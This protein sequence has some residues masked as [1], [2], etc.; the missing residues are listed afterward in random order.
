ATAWVPPLAGRARR[1]LRKAREAE[2]QVL[3][4]H[5][6]ET[7]LGLQ[8]RRVDALFA[9]PAPKDVAAAEVE[10]RQALAAWVELADDVEPPAE[11]AVSYPSFRDV[12]LCPE[13]TRPAVA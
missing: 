3:A 5:G 4:A 7:W 9:Q 6:Y 12:L 13:A 8:L 2:A 11:A 10:H 1:R